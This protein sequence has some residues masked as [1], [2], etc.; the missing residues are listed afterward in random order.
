MRALPQL[1]PKHLPEVMFQGFMCDVSGF[2]SKIVKNPNDAS[3]ASDA[4]LCGDID[5]T[6]MLSASSHLDTNSFKLWACSD[7]QQHTQDGAWVGGTPGQLVTPSPLHHSTS[8]L[9]PPTSHPHTHPP[10]R[11][12]PTC[13]STVSADVTQPLHVRQSLLAIPSQPGCLNQMYT[14]PTASLS[15]VHPQ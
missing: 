11:T 4:L 7:T 1:S 15:P 9:M 5:T 10:P 8:A 2:T 14:A 3:P 13:S 12:T 6:T